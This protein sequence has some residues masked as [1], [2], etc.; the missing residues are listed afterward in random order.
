MCLNLLVWDFHAQ[1]RGALGVRVVAHRSTW[2]SES[3][4]SAGVAL[5]EPA[6]RRCQA[7]PIW[8]CASCTRPLERA[9]SWAVVSLW[10][11]LAGAHRTAEGQRANNF[12]LWATRIPAFE[13]TP[14]PSF[15]W[16][17]GC[18][19]PGWFSI[20][21]QLVVPAA[22]VQRYLLQLVWRSWWN[23]VPQAAPGV[24]RDTKK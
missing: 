24:R 10:P 18:N 11:E 21:T 6:G 4:K 15:F 19:I 14:L 2:V 1:S 16:G 22:L 13:L 17:D 9:Q 20:C 3:M 12:V 8:P 23:K 5:E 7:V